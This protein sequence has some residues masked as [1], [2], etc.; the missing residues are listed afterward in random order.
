MRIEGSNDKVDEVER[1]SE[2]RNKLRA[3]YEKE[4]ENDP[5]SVS[6]HLRLLKLR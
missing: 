3:S 1:E 5:K 4:Q 2:V 6:A